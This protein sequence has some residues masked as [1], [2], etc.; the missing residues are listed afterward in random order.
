MNQNGIDEYRSWDAAYVLGSLVSSERH[1]FEEHLSGC[2]V[3]RAAVAELAGLPSLLAALSPEEAQSLGRTDGERP[4]PA[5]QP[6]LAN[7][8]QRGRRRTRLAA[9]GIMLGAAAAAGAVY[10]QVAGSPPPAA[11]I[12]AASATAL[13]FT[14]V[15]DS[16]LAATGS[17]TRSRGE[18][19]STGS[20]PTR[21]TRPSTLHP[22]PARRK[23]TVW[24]LSTPAVPRPRWPPGRQRRGQWRRRRPPPMSRRP[25]SAALKSVP[26]PAARRC[27]LR[28]RSAGAHAG[29]RRPDPCARR[30]RRRRADQRRRPEWMARTLLQGQW[31]RDFRDRAPA[32]SLLQGRL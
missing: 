16:A 18:R 28:T 6:G 32:P 31:R 14:P 11:Q 25:I 2:A 30:Q 12:Q 24:W 19:R 8:V 27:W 4:T 29:Q 10:V 20:A 13:H 1:E 22:V 23:S 21:R 17:L 3:C 5:L 9:A 15:A 7:K 26:S